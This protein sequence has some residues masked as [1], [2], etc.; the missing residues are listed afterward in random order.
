MSD[1]R[2]NKVIYS[3]NAVLLKVLNSVIQFILGKPYKRAKLTNERFQQE[4]RHPPMPWT[5]YT[6]ALIIKI[7]TICMFVC[8]KARKKPY[9]SLFHKGFSGSTEVEQRCLK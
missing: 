5:M 1:M 4:N 8:L 2:L 9:L 3:E 6:D 7:K